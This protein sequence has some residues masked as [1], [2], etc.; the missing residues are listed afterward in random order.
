MIHQETGFPCVNAAT[1]AG[2]GIDYILQRAR[3][4]V[5]PGDLVLLPLEYESYIE[6]GKLNSSLIDYVFARDTNYLRSVG[7]IKQIRFLSGISLSR[8]QT[9]IL[10]KFRTPER[11]QDY[12]KSENLNQYGDETGNRES[13]MSRKEYKALDSLKPRQDFQGYISS[14]HGMKIIQNFVDWSNTN[15]IKILAT[16]PNMLWFDVYQKDTYQTFFK[17]LEDFYDQIK[18]P[19]VGKPR[20]F[21]YDKSLFY[22]RIYHL[23]DQGV[24]HRTRQLIDLLKP[25]LEREMDRVKIQSTR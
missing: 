16:W 21:L 8:L 6:D 19:I 17:S 1:Y 9:G 18:V 4:L 22:D 23:N 20:D 25:I 24:H 13:G 5:K 3:S 2:L 11:W 10:G 7:F 12:Y 14:T 15:Q